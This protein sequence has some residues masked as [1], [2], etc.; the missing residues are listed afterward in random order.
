MAE[1][2]ANEELQ[3]EEESSAITLSSIW[4]IVVLNWQW[5]VL[6]TFVALCLAFA[7]LRYT[8]PV[9]T[10]SMKVLI[11][12]NESSNRRAMAGQMNL[13]NMGLIT[14][15]NGFE[16][17]LEIL[18]STNINSRVVKSLKL[19]VNY[20]IEG[21]I[22]KIEQYQN[23]P[24]IV[25][26]PQHQLAVL[27]TAINLEMT[28]SGKGL[29]VSGK[30]MLP[31][32]KEPVTFER[33]VKKLP[34]SINTPMGVI[35]FQQN[36]GTKWKDEQL[37][38]TILPI[39][40]AARIYR[41]KL[42]AAPTSKTTTVAQV[43]F[44]DTQVGRSLDYLN[45]LFKSYND[46]ANEDKNEVAMKT[47]EF[48]KERIDFIR[49]ELDIT[50]GELEQ[51]KK[52][53][54]LINLANDATNALSST[55]EYQKKQ[56]ELETQLNII[57]SL[58]NYVNNPA[59]AMQVIPA[60]IGLDNASLNEVIKK[61]NEGVLQRNRLLKSSSEDNPFVQRITSQLGEMWPS[62]R[63]SLEAIR[64]DIMTQKSS[65]D[66]QYRMFS[67]RITSTPT[68]E[69]A[70]TNMSRQQEIK[71]NLYLMLLQKREENYISLASTAAKARIIDSPQYV[72][73][74][75][76]K[77]KI[78][79]LAALVFGACLP[80]GIIL[81]L[82][83]LRY[84]IEGREDIEK[85]TKISI[86]ADI[87]LAGKTVD[88]EKALVVRE[89]TNNS[90]EEAFRGLRTNLRFVLEGDEKVILCTSCIPGEG[91]TFVSTNLA[92]SL[93]L[94]GKKV[95]IVGLDIRKP[96]LVKLFGISAEKKGLT[97]FLSGEDMSYDV[98]EAQ[99]VHGVAN[100]NLDV[101]PAGVIPPNPGELIS[102]EQLDRAMELL[103]E[104]YD[105][106]LLDTPPIGLVSDTLSI[107][108]VA[109][110]CLFV[111]RA[112][113]SPRANFDL[114]NSLSAENKLPKI[115]LVLNAVDMKK[116]KYGYYYGY[117]KYGKYGKYGRYGRYGKYGYGYG[118]YG[119][120]GIYGHYGEHAEKEHIEK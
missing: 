69:R 49:G 2:V 63:M 73:Q 70:L 8:Q 7:Y 24:I 78:I 51:Y 46:D 27:K 112:D 65:A 5:I 21:R 12:D 94:M 71:A 100:K 92:M 77:S 75:A 60:N 33:E 115:N 62:I 81:L 98:L 90:M 64:S 4:T 113:Y 86:L 25:D 23:N 50:E 20:A 22:K 91:K 83:L 109:D 74:V 99:I 76:P 55:T 68:Q 102:R 88:G 26:M 87:P 101:L 34:G 1:Y 117:G 85:L 57:N 114:I 82:S 38:A 80:V 19:Y 29:H 43:S 53:N 45:E 48:I 59:N 18:N 79:W 110:M 120:Y 118:R 61:Y 30:F 6:S 40:T 93:A 96:R 3:K 67:G 41:G 95:V 9:F 97:T 58:V 42:S 119:H 36:P 107:G 15:S 14:N 54:E 31:G 104:H 89:N 39:E 47:E 32:Q 108:R 116:K 28:K 72:G 16:N 66:N 44:T 106:V 52:S 17:E 13:E 84:R 103:K 37:Y 105:Y 35:I 10:S 11:K 111:C 56:V